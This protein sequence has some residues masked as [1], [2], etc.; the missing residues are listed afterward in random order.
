MNSDLVK[1]FGLW[2]PIGGDAVAGAVG[3]ELGVVKGEVSPL[4]TFKIKNGVNQTS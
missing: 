2:T 3:G 1:Y 4:I